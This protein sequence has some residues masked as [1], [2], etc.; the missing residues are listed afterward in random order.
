[1]RTTL[2]HV[3]A[4]AGVSIKTVSNVIHNHPN[5]TE[6]TKAKVQAAI[7]ELSYSPNLSARSLRSGKTNVIGLAIPELLNSYFTELANFV[8]MAA[9][10]RGLTVLIEQTRGNRDKELQILDNAQRNLVDGMIYSPLGLQQ[11][12]AELTKVR[13][14]L[15]LVGENIFNGPNDHVTMKNIESAKA[16]TEYLIKLGHKRIAVIGAHK[17]EVIGS[18]GLRLTGYKQA[19]KKAGIKYDETLIGYSAPWFRSNGA[20]VMTELLNRTR[21]FTAVFALNDLL[22]FGAMRVLQEAGIQ[23][24]RDV[25]VMGFDNL[26]EAKYSIPSLSSVE[27]GKQEIAERAVLN[28]L[29]RMNQGDEVPRPAR[30]IEVEFSIVERESTGLATVTKS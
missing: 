27:P 30:E 5:V 2:H 1:M 21:D 9:E 28:L 14:P 3:A 4:A 8:I 10:K 7:E 22:A 11:E 13:Y 24:P 19:L 26:E 18:A 23:I 20:A 16:A 6:K 29:E 12:D 25:S 17:G 15:V